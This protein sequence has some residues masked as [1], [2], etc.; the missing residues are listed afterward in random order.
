MMDY[1]LPVTVTTEGIPQAQIALK[2]LSKG[3]RKAG[4]R[5]VHR[6]VKFLLKE[7]RKVTPKDTGDLRRSGK[8][9]VNTK[10]EIITGSISFYIYYAIYVHEDLTKRHAEG[11]YAK[12]LSRTVRNTQNIR[13]G[14]MM[15]AEEI[16]KEQMKILPKTKV[17]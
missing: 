5:G 7:T 12:F 14:R 2:R 4:A 9:I 17:S 8:A 16:A 15:I 13:L 3:M 11:T 1:R 10:G 6:Y